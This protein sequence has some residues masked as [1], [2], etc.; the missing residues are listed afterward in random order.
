M[1][2]SPLT[3]NSKKGETT[4]TIDSSPSA[5]PSGRPIAITVLCIFSAIGVLFVI[6][7]LFSQAAWSIGSWYPPSLAVSAIIGG[8]CTVGFWLMRRWALYLYT[9]MF[10]VNQIILLA[11]GIWT[12]S[13]LIL[14]AI[15]LAIGFYYLSRMR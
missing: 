14:P 15:V 12:I 7:L 3:T 6:P 13:A 8:A 1:H 10:V 11:M 4:M 5:V 2:H 9:A